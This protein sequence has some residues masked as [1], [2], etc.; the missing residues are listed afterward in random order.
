MFP[1]TKKR[2]KAFTEGAKEGV[3]IL[4]SLIPVFMIAAF[5]EGFVTRYYTMPQWLSA[6]ILLCSVSYIGWYYIIYPIQVQKN[7]KMTRENSASA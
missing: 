7:M 6:L 2:L 4:V 3:I 5:F 1:G